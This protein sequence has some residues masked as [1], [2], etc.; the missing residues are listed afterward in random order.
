[1]LSKCLDLVIH[2]FFSLDQAVELVMNICEYKVLDEILKDISDFT[3][4]VALEV[5]PFPDE[6]QR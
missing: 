6:C 2:L 5:A 1:M 4:Y 3:Q